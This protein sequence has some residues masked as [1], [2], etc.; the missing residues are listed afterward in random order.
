MW[1]Q[2]S[3]KVR[4]LCPFSLKRGGWQQAWAPPVSDATVSHSEGW[5]IPRDKLKIEHELCQGDYELNIL[6]SAFFRLLW[7]CYSNLVYK[8]N[9]ILRWWIHCSGPYFTWIIYAVSKF[10]SVIH[11]CTWAVWG[12][13]A[14]REACR[15]AVISCDIVWV[16]K[17]A[18][19]RLW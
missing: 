13:C 10:H 9:A 15:L 5:A 16:F 11:T 19:K 14:C 1:C 17:M 6:C 18:S 2:K 4:R 12:V 3:S 7:S 8:V